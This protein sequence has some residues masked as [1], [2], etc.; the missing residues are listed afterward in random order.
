[1][2]IFCKGFVAYVFIIGENPV[3]F[4]PIL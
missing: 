3:S 2:T 1:M 4:V